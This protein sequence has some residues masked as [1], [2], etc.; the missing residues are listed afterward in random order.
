MQIALILVITQLALQ[1]VQIIQLVII[2]LMLQKMMVAAYMMIA[3]VNV[4]AQ[5]L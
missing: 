2:M 1:D 5:Q 4:V 3:Q